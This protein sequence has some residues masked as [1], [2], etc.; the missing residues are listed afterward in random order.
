MNIKIACKEKKRK[1]I[2]KDLEAKLGTQGKGKEPLQ[3]TQGLG[4]DEEKEN[5]DEEEEEEECDNGKSLIFVMPP[6]KKD[7]ETKKKLPMTP[8]LQNKP[9]TREVASV[10]Y[11]FSIFYLSDT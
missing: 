6:R 8:P 2:I 4:K 1:K 5:D 11:T 7:Q 9:R 3:L 10:D